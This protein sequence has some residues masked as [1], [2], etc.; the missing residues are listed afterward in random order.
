[1]CRYG[2]QLL[3]EC[4][5][6]VPKKSENITE[7]TELD[8]RALKPFWDFNTEPALVNFEQCDPIVKEN[9]KITCLNKW[10]QTQCKLGCVD[11]YQR[12]GFIT[13]SRY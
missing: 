10:G 7:L 11:H 4:S 1:M 5:E 6:F 13:W 12:N 9:S 3:F 8:C 2:S